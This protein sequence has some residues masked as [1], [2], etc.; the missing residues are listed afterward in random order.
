MTGNRFGYSG[1]K[2]KCVVLAASILLASFS[3]CG[4]FRTR[5]PRTSHSQAEEE[6]KPGEST[7]PSPTP[8]PTP[9]PDPK[10]EAMRIATQVGLS[11]GDLRGRYDLFPMYAEAVSSNQNFKG[12][13]EYL[14]HLYPIVAD[15]LKT[16]I[17]NPIC[18]STAKTTSVRGGAG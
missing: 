6:V 10:I 15:H 18:Y 14:Y 11:E 8:S 1:M 13:Y 3:L 12:K 17:C 7:E 16:I 9:T 4:C 2:L 5:S